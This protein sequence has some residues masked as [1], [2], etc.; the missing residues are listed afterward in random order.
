[1]HWVVVLAQGVEGFS[2]KKAAAAYW[3][4]F[5]WLSVIIL[6]LGVMLLGIYF[7]RRRMLREETDTAADQLPLSLDEVRRMHRAGK[8][9][10][11]EMA[12]LKEIVMKKSRE[13]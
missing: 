4:V 10:D 5:F 8:I 11:A 12:R 9:D 2:E 3:T 1:M 13:S 7:Y 6:I